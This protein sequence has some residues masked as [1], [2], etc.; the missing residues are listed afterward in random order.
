MGCHTWVYRKKLESEQ[1]CS[2]ADKGF[3]EVDELHDIIRISGYPED[4]LKSFDEFINFVNNN[5]TRI[6][7]Y[8]DDWKETIENFFLQNTD[9]YIEFG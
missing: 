5:K 1:T 6:S 2:T 4:R 3:I 8:G 7:Y 9:G